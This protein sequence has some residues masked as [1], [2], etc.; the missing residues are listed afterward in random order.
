MRV[1][2]CLAGILLFFGLPGCTITSPREVEIGF[3]ERTRNYA[4]TLEQAGDLKRALYQWEVLAS[5][6]PADEEART[7][8][9][10]LRAAIQ[11]R[12]RRLEQQ[13]ASAYS[14]NQTEKVKTSALRILTLDGRHA[15]AREK[16]MEIDRNVALL[17]QHQK[18]RDALQAQATRRFNAE[19]LAAL[20]RLLEQSANYSSQQKFLDISRAVDS[21]LR[22]YPENTQARAL[23]ANTLVKLGEQS[24]SNGQLEIA[25]K[26]FE[27]A[28]ESGADNREA[29]M[30]TV[31]DIHTDLAEDLYRKGLE[32]FSHDL[33]KAIKFWKESLRHNPNHKAVKLRLSRAEKMLAT[34]KKIEAGAR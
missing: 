25:V 29:L 16:L 18:D 1:S 6:Q 33:D 14:K 10:R 9:T 12:L 17:N 7:A 22:T 4:L 13:L 19:E 11:A 2:L 3:V 30:K 8:I 26:Y 24:R 31:A 27:N 34:L 21:F 28:I 5:T 32:V 15:D 20:N 23:K